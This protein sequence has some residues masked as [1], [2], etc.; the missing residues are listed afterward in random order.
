MAKTQLTTQEQAQINFVKD[1]AKAIYSDYN[2]RKFHIQKQESYQPSNYWDGGSRTYS[3]AI[4]F[5][6]QRVL[7]PTH[8][9]TVPWNKQAHD[10]FE[11]PQGVGIL[12][13]TYF[14]GKDMGITLVIH[15]NQTLSLEN[16][17]QNLL[18]KP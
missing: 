13:H 8:E 11:I 16:N 17:S 4:D 18:D 6:G 10:S 9:S 15:P 1:L 12:E 7:M 2:G 14:C 3:V 5:R